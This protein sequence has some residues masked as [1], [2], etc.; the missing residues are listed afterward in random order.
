MVA[1][2]CEAELLDCFRRI[3]RREVELSADLK[4]PLEVDDV[5]AWIVGPRAFLLLRDRPD[6]RPRGIVFNRSAGV[7][8]HIVAMCNWCH[9]V[10]GH[11]AIRL[12]SASVDRRR[13]IGVFVCG[14]LSC[15]VR[16]R[17]SPNPRGAGQT[18][19]RIREF[20]NRCL[21]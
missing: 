11:G 1:V 12:M 13:T 2:T 7:M 15:M 16:A 3:D 10:R 17:E 5:F 18:L 14:D 21:F 19:R 6:D 4:L 9:S 20:A 8:P